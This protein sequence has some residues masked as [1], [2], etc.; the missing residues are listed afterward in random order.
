MEI[1]WT[2]RLRNEEVVQRAREE[3]NIL[4]TIQ[5]R[6]ANWIGHIFC[7]NCL[8]KHVISRKI[9]GRIKV[10]GRRRRRCEQLLGVLKEKRGYWNWKH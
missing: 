5:S 3:R 4:H 6:K 7:R 2:D 10:T 1:R 9:D 8:L